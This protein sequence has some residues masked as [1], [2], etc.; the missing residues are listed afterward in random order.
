MATYVVTADANTD[1]DD[2]HQFKYRF[3]SQNG[4]AVAQDEVDRRRAAG[5]PVA[6]WRWERGEATLV[7]HYNAASGTS[8]SGGGG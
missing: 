6:L 7:E 8:L 2:E 5:K 4:S 3:T 1:W